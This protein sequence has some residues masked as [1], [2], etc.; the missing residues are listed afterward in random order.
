M[1][2][3]GEDI[4]FRLLLAPQELIDPVGKRDLA[5]LAANGLGFRNQEQLAVQV[6]ILPALVQQLPTPHSR[7]ECRHDDRAEMLGTRFEQ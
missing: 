1:L 5:G 3:V 2:P 4:T 7:I 6:H